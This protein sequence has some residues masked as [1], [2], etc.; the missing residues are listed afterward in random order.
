MHEGNIGV[1]SSG[2]MG[3][4][5]T[6]YV[7]LKIAHD[8]DIDALSSIE[9]SIPSSSDLSKVDSHEPLSTGEVKPVVVEESPKSDGQMS[10]SVDVIQSPSQSSQ[11]SLFFALTSMSPKSTASTPPN[12]AL[13]PQA[14]PPPPMKHTMKVIPGDSLI[15]GIKLSRALVVDDVASNRKMLG[16][17]IQSRFHHIDY[18]ENGKIAVDLVQESESNEETTRFSV[19][20]MDCN[21]P[22]TP[23]PTPPYPLLFD[24]FLLS[25]LPQTLNFLFLLLSSHGWNRSNQ[26]N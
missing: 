13:P 8:G 1:V 19:I 18:A 17:V 15:E 5:C 4:G 10:I 20:F 2:A 7:D 6:F 14:I 3:D 24:L 9:G 25:L 21:M 22:G 26:K 12:A 23:P 16:R 11:P